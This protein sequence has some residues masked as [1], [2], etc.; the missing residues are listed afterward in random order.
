MSQL[1][2]GAWI[3]GL[4]GTDLAAE[5]QSY[6]TFA[7]A[8]GVKDAE[9]NGEKTLQLL[10]RMATKYLTETGLIK[11]ALE[12]VSVASARGAPC[13]PTVTVPDIKLAELEPGI[14]SGNRV[15][16]TEFLENFIASIDNA[17]ATDQKK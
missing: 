11:A 3:S 8:M 12:D 6:A 10:K 9:V 7:Q 13:A 1:R 5:T 15:T 2:P 17:K 14:F 4:T 16:W